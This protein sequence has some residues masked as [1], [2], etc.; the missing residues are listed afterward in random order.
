M[1]P[2]KEQIEQCIK[3][4]QWIKFN[5]VG[6]EEPVPHTFE[7]AAKVYLENA[8]NILNEVKE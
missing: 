4:L 8:I 5:V 7:F 2:T 1:K 6:E 3:S